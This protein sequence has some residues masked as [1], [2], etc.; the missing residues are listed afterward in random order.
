MLSLDTTIN[1]KLSVGLTKRVDSTQ[2]F[3]STFRLSAEE[4][5]EKEYFC[6]FLLINRVIREEFYFQD[7]PLHRGSPLSTVELMLKS[8]MV[9]NLNAT[10]FYPLLLY[11]HSLHLTIQTKL[12]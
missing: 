3:N 12:L 2:K 10:P 11:K 4:G 7:F 8:Q 5:E 6:N 1:M 9:T